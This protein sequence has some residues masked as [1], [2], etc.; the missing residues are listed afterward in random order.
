MTTRIVK[1]KIVEEGK[2]SQTTAEKKIDGI[3]GYG[4]KDSDGTDYGRISVLRTK[5]VKEAKKNRRA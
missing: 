2:F 1:V 5:K 4:L 3:I